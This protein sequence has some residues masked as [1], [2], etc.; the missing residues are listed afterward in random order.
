MLRQRHRDDWSLPG[1]LLDRGE[2]P[3]TAVRRELR[4]ELGLEVEV[5]SPTATLVDP[6]VRR[7]DVIYRIDLPARIEVEPRGEAFQAQWIRP[8]FLG[9]G[10]EATAAALAEMASAVRAGATGVTS[11]RLL[12]PPTT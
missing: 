5:G 11:G 12:A 2:A 4:E 9:E 8:E 1:G 10:S 7:V 6:H 3:D